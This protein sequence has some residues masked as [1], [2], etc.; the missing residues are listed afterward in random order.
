MRNYHVVE[1]FLLIG[2][3]FSFIQEAQGHPEAYFQTEGAEWVRLDNDSI[4][5]GIHLAQYTYSLDVIN[6]ADDSHTVLGNITYTLIADNIVDIGD[7]EYATRNG[8]FIHWVYPQDRVIGEQGGIFMEVGSG[9]YYSKYIPL[10]IN[11]WTN[12]SIF[13]SDGFQLAKFNVTFENSTYD[14]IWGG[15][16]VGEYTKANAT[17]LFDT[18]S[19]DAPICC[20]Q[21]NAHQIHFNLVDKSLVETN[22][23][24]NF[25][26][27][28]KLNLTKNNDTTISAI[29][30]KPSFAVAYVTEGS[31]SAGGTNFTVT[32]PADMLPEHVHYASASTNIS[33]TW[34]HTS[35]FLRGMRL[36][37]VI[38]AVNATTP[39]ITPTPFPTTTPTPTPTPIPTQTPTST[40][41]STPIVGGKGDVNGDNQVT[42]VDALFISQYTVGLRTLSSSQL[43]AADVNGD[44]QVTVV[45]ALFIAQTTV[46][47]RQL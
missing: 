25:S 34:K 47:L 36:N 18:F 37:E 19:T 11:R 40:P 32:T 5:S 9:Y 45:D 20:L 43:A 3:I 35:F 22:R 39:T 12:K 33:N 30:Y 1:L 2:L 4:S 26:V 13:N 44:G 41:T 17:I 42:V 15:I 29:E 7:E 46:G 10:N 31:Y 24:Y 28:I 23:A 38:K 14:S 21:T 8:S 27:V 16:D 6:I